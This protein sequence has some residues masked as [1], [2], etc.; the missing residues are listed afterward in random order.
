[1]NRKEGWKEKER[2]EKETDGKR[3]C[4]KRKEKMRAG[5]K[6]KNK[7]RRRQKKAEVAKKKKETGWARKENEKKK[8]ISQLGLSQ[9]TGP[10]PIFSPIVMDTHCSQAQFNLGPKDPKPNLIWAPATSK[11]DQFRYS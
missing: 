1:M 10:K 11:A 3:P 2:K 9:L 4:M 6:K 8:R 5:K 7:T